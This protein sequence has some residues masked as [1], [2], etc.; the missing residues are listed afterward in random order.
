ME[1]TVEQWINEIENEVGKS[2]TKWVSD[3]RKREYSVFNEN[4]YWSNIL[5]N[6]DGVAV[7]TWAVLMVRRWYTRAAM[8]LGNTV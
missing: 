2:E 4:R 1:I 7:N 3:W 5:G 8:I 6:M